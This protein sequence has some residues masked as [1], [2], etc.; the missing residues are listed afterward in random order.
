VRK[1]VKIF[2]I[3]AG[4]LALLIVAYLV[5]GRTLRMAYANYLFGQGKYPEALKIYEDMAVDQPKSPY[6]LHNRALGYYQQGNYQ[7]SSTE[8]QNAAKTLEDS[9]INSKELTN[10]FQYHLG[11]S[12]FKWGTKSDSS[13]QSNQN[14]NEVNPFEQAVLSY[15]KAMEANPKDKDAKYNYELALLHLKQPKSQQQ[16]PNPNPTPKP[17]EDLLNANKQDEKYLPLVPILD[18]P[19]DKD[20]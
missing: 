8:M 18:K 17:N 5:W 3:I 10:R 16:Q 9:K 7:R 19:V 13:A 4:A 12:F 2:L 14:G 11:N 1:G 20:W 6:T 15:K